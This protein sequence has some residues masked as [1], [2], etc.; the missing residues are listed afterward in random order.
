[1]ANRRTVTPQRIPFHKTSLGRLPPELLHAIFTFAR[2]L[3]IPQLRLTSKT[4]ALIGFSHLAKT[5]HLLFTSP[6]FDRAG[7]IATHPL[8]GKCVQSLVYRIDSL[9]PYSVANVY[10]TCFPDVEY[11]DFGI[12]GRRPPP[13]LGRTKTR[14]ERAWNREIV[15]RMAPRP[16]ARQVEIAKANYLSLWKDQ[17]GLRHDGHF[18]ANKLSGLFR[19]FSNLKIVKLCCDSG[20]DFVTRVDH[21]D[22]GG[23]GDDDEYPSQKKRSLQPLLRG[24][25]QGL[26]FRRG[27]FQL[28][29]LFSALHVTSTY[30]HTLSFGYFD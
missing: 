12:N 10:R 4:L 20:G 13:P 30:L 16:R 25:D 6:S 8:L 24:G 21:E 9:P 1:M 26:P 3:D 15:R 19:R 18:A 11:D 27:T 14:G 5:L 28:F 22:G 7:R 17:E 23:D 29:A 2:P